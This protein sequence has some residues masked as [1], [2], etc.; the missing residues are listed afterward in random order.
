LL[1]EPVS[2]VTI[3]SLELMPAWIASPAAGVRRSAARLSSEIL[4]GEDEHVAGVA[5]PGTNRVLQIGATFSRRA[6]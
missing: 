5:Q 6:L 4:G 1:V 2:M 3:G